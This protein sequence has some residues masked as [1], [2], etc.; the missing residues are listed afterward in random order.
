METQA[1]FVGQI[2][3]HA[4]I[5]AISDALDKS[6]SRDPNVSIVV[7]YFSSHLISLRF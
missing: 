6:V 1:G 2:L 7:F 5:S 4:E 3:Y